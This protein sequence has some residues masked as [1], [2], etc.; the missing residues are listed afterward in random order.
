[1]IGGLCTVL[2]RIWTKSTLGYPARK[3]YLAESDLLLIR[4]H[5][6]RPTL[7]VLLDLMGAGAESVR[8]KFNQDEVSFMA[9]AVNAGWLS[10]LDVE[11]LSRGIQIQIRDMATARDLSEYDASLAKMGRT[12]T[13]YTLLIQR[14]RNL[15][16]VEVVALY[17]DL[18]VV[19]DAAKRK[20][21]EPPPEL[22]A[23]AEPAQ[24]ADVN[25]IPS[26]EYG[27]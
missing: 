8:A 24:D 2:A 19:G 23:Y 16:N 6:K 14:I 17:D 25:D 15:T 7:S 21:K 12:R 26:P 1:M 4:S 3:K 13:E 10:A 9:G 5:Q 20:L 18:R 11:S 27:R 22:L